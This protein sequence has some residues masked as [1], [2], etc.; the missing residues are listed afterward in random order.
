MEEVGILRHHADRSGQAL[1]RQV[2]H[3]VPVD[4]DPAPGHVVEA[5][6][7]VAER[8]LASTR[9]PDQRGHGAG[10]RAQRNAPQDPIR[11]L[12]RQLPVLA[13]LAGLFRLQRSDRVADGCWVAEPDVLQL[14]LAARVDQIPGAGPLRDGVGSVQHFEDAL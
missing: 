2:A 10:L 12:C 14:D 7:Q 9:V 8:C 6:H 5:R 3:V 13:L 1:Q 4:Q 11:G